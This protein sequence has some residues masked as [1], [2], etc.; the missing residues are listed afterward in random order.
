MHEAVADD[1]LRQFP[2]LPAPHPPVR[3]S[4]PPVRSPLG[5]IELTA[6]AGNAPS[7]VPGGIDELE[8]G[9]LRGHPD[10]ARWRPV[11]AFTSCTA[12]SLRIAGSDALQHQ[13]ACPQTNTVPE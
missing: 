3:S 8:E 4:H 13:V 12:Q 6:G 9:L 1:P 7:R 2:D 10:T 11:S 5:E